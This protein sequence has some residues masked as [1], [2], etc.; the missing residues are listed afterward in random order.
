MQSAPA[1]DPNMSGISMPP[2]CAV[3]AARSSASL[4]GAPEASL[5]ASA[6]PARTRSFDQ[7]GPHPVFGHT[8]TCICHRSPIPVMRWVVAF[9]RPC[10]R[11]IHAPGSVPLVIDGSAGR[12]VIHASADRGND[13]Q[14]KSEDVTTCRRAGMDGYPASRL[15]LAVLLA[16]NESRASGISETL[17]N[18]AGSR[19][20]GDL[21]RSGHLPGGTLV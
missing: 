11:G 17:S 15:L 1:R 14:C 16:H 8:V 4:L 2:S 6:Y 12:H 3:R 7:I 9:P 21:V 5:G 18:I 13:R 10:F 19:H 20:R